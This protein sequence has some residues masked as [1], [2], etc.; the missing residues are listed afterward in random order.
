MSRDAGRSAR[1]ITARRC[2]RWSAAGSRSGP[3]RSASRISACC[4]STSCPNSSAPVL[5]SLRQ[6]L[7]TGK[8][9]V[10]RANAHVTFPARVQLVAAMNPCRCGHLGDPALACSRAPRCAADYQAQGVGAAARPHR[11]PCRR[12]GRQR[13]RPRPCRR[14]P[15]AAPRSRSG[16]PRRASVQTAALQRHGRPHQCRSRRRA[17]RRASRRPTSRAASCSP[18]R[19]R[20][21]GCRARGFH[22]VLRVARTIADLAGASRSAG[23]TSPRR[24]A[25]AGRRRAI[26]AATAGAQQRLPRARHAQAR[27]VPPWRNGRRARTQNRVLQGVSVRVGPGAPVTEKASPGTG[28]FCGSVRIS[29]P[30]WT[31]GRARPR[32]SHAATFPKLSKSTSSRAS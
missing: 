30:R 23:S 7:E 20:R 22:R 8:V 11:P 31:A 2:R 6:P 18:R 16:S 10:A 1:R 17:A 19:P 26:D 9:S 21:C 28:L 13:R 3:A 15:R 27:G 32:S 12:P 29:S 25:T 4:S 24:S 5:D 14:P